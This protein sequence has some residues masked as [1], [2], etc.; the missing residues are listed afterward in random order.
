[1]TAL[2][3]PSIVL[4]DMTTQG[5]HRPTLSGRCVVPRR[6]GGDIQGATWRD[7][8]RF[9]HGHLTKKARVELRPADVPMWAVSDNH[10]VRGGALFLDA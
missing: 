8:S 6:L 3:F 10:L 2:A 9:E 4:R 1:V 5:S 7:D